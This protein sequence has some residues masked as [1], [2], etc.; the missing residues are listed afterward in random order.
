MARLETLIDYYADPSVRA[1][2]REYAGGSPDEAP[3]SVYVAALQGAE[4]QHAT[5]DRASHYAIDSLDSLLARGADIARSMWDTAA[6]LIH[7]DID[8][9]NIDAPGEA[10]HHPAEVFFK[11]EPVYR[12]T[13]HVL[14]RFG[15][16]LF[17]LMTGQGYHFTG[18]V[19][20]DSA[21][22]DR[23]A[24]LVPEMP[25]WLAAVDSRRPS[26]VTARIS[27]RHARAHVAVGML[28]EFLTHRIL[29]RARRRSPIPIV[30]NGTVVGD[31]FVGRECV[32]LDISHAGDPLDVRHVRVAFGAYQKHRFRPD[33]VQHRGASER[34]PFIA[35]PR[36]DESLAHL[37]S[38]G[39][40]LRHAARAAREGSAVL[41]IVADGI[42]RVIAAY[43]RSSLGA[44]HRRFYS[45][46]P[47]APD[48][49]E[50]VFRSVPLET[51][52]ACVVHP[53]VE[54]NDRLLQPAV[55]QHVTRAL[56]AGGMQPR[57][58]AAV[59]HSRYASDF[60]WARRWSWLDAQ[61]RAEFDVRVF[62]GLMAV[63]IDGALDFNCRSAQEKGL[64]PGT[65][66]GRDLRVDRARLLERVPQ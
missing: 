61:T 28:A 54:A 51:L 17:A 47:H 43:E 52:P 1:R 24:S 11:L 40:D 5:W 55:I 45:T 6:L 60:G 7:L 31:G 27:D 21:V 37:L 13:Q 48:D 35:V 10:Y 32:S 41:P 38:H 8:Y 20:L 4:G 39:R 15:M 22:V 46:R 59:V 12:A 63:G 16:P 3:T 25:G 62:A 23:L 56:M 44:F 14:G 9:L 18:R 57:E 2:I 64:C 29:L 36:G 26:W 65:T 53:L 42:A 34:P 19:P 33:I 58:I 66:C 49:L 30:L 50:A